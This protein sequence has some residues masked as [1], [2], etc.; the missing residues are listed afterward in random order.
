M[1]KK[2]YIGNTLAPILRFISKTGQFNKNTE[3]IFT[4]PHYIPVRN[5]FISSINID[6]RDP[7]GE[8]IRFENDLSKTLVKLHFRPI[9]Q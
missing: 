4:D 9:K 8:P 5:S 3:K 2:K 1:K 7:S 6:I